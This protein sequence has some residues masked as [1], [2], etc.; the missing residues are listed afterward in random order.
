MID[1]TSNPLIWHLKASDL[2]D[3]GTDS[4][5]SWANREMQE[6]SFKKGDILSFRED[7]DLYVFSII[8]GS[9]KLTSNT[10]SG[11]ETILDI[12]GPGDI[13]GPLEQIIETK[14]SHT[15]SPIK[16]FATEAVATSTGI[17]LKF[18]I[19]R[20]RNIVENRPFMMVNVTRLLGLHNTRFQLRISRLL[21]R[22]SLGKVAGLLTELAERHSTQQK[23]G[24]HQI[25]VKLTH[26]DMAS[27]TGLKRE[28]VS[29]ALGILEM[30]EYIR[31]EK[32]QISI[33]RL[34]DL[35]DVQ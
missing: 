33:L 35:S 31:T 24:S 14:N 34:S 17:A 8:E 13:F 19:N 11:K 7:A 30:D 25:N 21:Y 26:Q 3:G 32:R 22:S 12:A 15:P 29:E 18:E 1:D 10:E 20:F 27:M 4:V 9:I 23:D 5:M 6:V 2:F 28:T 16:S